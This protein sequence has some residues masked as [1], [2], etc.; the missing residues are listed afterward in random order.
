MNDTLDQIDLTDIFTTFHPKAAIQIL[1]KYTW[2]ILQYRLH[3]GPQISTQQVKKDQD[4]T[5]HIF[6]TQ[7]YET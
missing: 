3:T 2:N 7:P 4:H 6:R 5:M 1:I